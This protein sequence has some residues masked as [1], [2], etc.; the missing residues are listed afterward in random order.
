MQ[1]AGERMAVVAAYLDVGCGMLL[2]FGVWR[3]GKW[4]VQL[5]DAN[6]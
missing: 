3:L 6:N 1:N 4:A 5:G 2:V